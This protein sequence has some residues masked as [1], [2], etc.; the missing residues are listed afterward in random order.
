MVPVSSWELAWAFTS[1]VVEPEL[2]LLLGG[3]PKQAVSSIEV[4]TV[5][6]RR[7]NKRRRLAMAVEMA[8]AIRKKTGMGCKKTGGNNRLAAHVNGL[9]F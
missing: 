7:A 6:A 9:C 5:P 1:V 3:F 4:V 8:M 2:P